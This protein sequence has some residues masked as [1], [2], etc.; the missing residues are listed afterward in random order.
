MGVIA[1]TAYLV[2]M[3]CFIPFAF[4]D[5]GNR[6][7]ENGNTENSNTGNSNT[8]NS[9]LPPPAG[10]ASPAFLAGMGASRQAPSAM[11]GSAADGFLLSK[12]LCGLLAICCMCFL[13]FADNVLDLRWR[14]KL[15]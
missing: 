1:G 3:F 10:G 12:Y 13:G 11:A 8:E 15:W 14:D 4:Y 7:T 6:N 5:S 2:S 9:Y